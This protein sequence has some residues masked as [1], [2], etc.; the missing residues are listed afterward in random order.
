MERDQLDSTFVP[1]WLRSQKIEEKSTFNFKS[2]SV[3]ANA[4]TIASSPSAIITQTLQVATSDISASS[5]NIKNNDNITLTGDQQSPPKL[6]RSKSSPHMEHANGGGSPSFPSG[7]NHNHN[8][9]NSQTSHHNNSHH[10]AKTFS[11]LISSE[12][13]HIAL[14]T[15]FDYNSTKN[16]ITP[17]PINFPHTFTSTNNN[18]SD[19]V[20]STNITSTNNK[21]KTH[22]N[23]NI[24]GNNKPP[25]VS[26]KSQP[27]LNSIDP[28]MA[29]SINFSKPYSNNNNINNY[30]P[31]MSGYYRGYS[32][33][34]HMNNSSNNNNNPNV[35]SNNS[36]YHSSNSL[37][38]STN[39]IYSN[40][41]NSNINNNSS[42]GGGVGHSFN[43]IVN[44]HHHHHPHSSG[45]HPHHPHDFDPLS[46]SSSSN[47]SSLSSSSSSL[48]SSTSSFV[49]NQETF[50]QFSLSDYNNQYNSHYNN[51]YNSSQYYNSNIHNIPEETNFEE[52]SQFP[53]L[54]TINKSTKLGRSTSPTLTINIPVSSP[55]SSPTPLNQQTPP[56][57]PNNNSSQVP[58]TPTLASL[59]SPPTIPNPSIAN[60]AVGSSLSSA[61]LPSSTSAN[62]P[63]SSSSSSNNT[64]EKEKAKGLVPF[65]KSRSTSSQPQTSGTQSTSPSQTPIGLL[66]PSQMK[67]S[68]AVGASAQQKT[69]KA[70][71]T[72]PN[73]GD[74]KSQFR[75]TFSEPTFAGIANKDDMVPPS[76]KGLTD[77]SRKVKIPNPDKL[78]GK[79][80]FFEKLQ[81]E[82]NTKIINKSATAANKPIISTTTITT[83]KESI[84]IQNNEEIKEILSNQTTCTLK[85]QTVFNNQ[86]QQ[87]LNVN[88]SPSIDKDINND[89][90][91]HINSEGTEEDEEHEERFLRGLGWIPED[92]DPISDSEIEEITLKMKSIQNNESFQKCYI[93]T[94]KWR[95]IHKNS[96]NQGNGENDEA[97][98]S[99]DNLNESNGT[100]EDGVVTEGG[101]IRCRGGDNRQIINNK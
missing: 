35:Y 64:D 3:L 51:Q 73:R 60:A 83:N 43:H 66:V 74:L 89:S 18:D 38:N 25:L 14:P 46:S 92:E 11:P 23:N 37:N 99:E 29:N 61:S 63:G 16:F 50:N 67:K 49:N 27:N 5:A 65:I 42:G 24:G 91:D 93:S 28:S 85:S 7:L 100:A 96:L 59:I 56:T 58:N 6:N 97:V 101:V 4:Q 84:S 80:K 19:E 55:S 30:Y 20:Y 31:N 71:P 75:K 95:S 94:T 40:N 68:G 88:S 8:N 44:S 86:H 70:P 10:S 98:E 15:T 36:L 52:D 57:T 34:N 48:S 45:H 54:Q 87:L 39:S 69:L 12:K 1:E 41:S 32:S 72:I 47:F 62:G 77:P 17:K 53:P 13:T 22:S 9:N 81:S 78:L 82:S 2:N 76:R 90:D 33:Y 21:Y 26:F 79:E